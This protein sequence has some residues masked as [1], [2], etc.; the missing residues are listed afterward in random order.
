MDQVKAATVG[1]NLLTDGGFEAGPEGQPG[2]WVEE[3]GTLDEV[4]M[5]ATW[6]KEAD[7][8]PP[9]KIQPPKA[10]PKDKNA[11]WDALLKPAEKPKPLTKE[12]KE[13]KQCLLL[14]VGHRSQDP[15]LQ[16]WALEG[17]YLAYNSPPVRL[18]P[19]SLVQISGWI[20]IPGQIQGSPDGALLFDSA[21]GE[22]LAVRLIEPTPWK[23]F[24]LYRKVPASG[25]I[26]VTVALTG[27]GRVYFDD[28]RIEP[29]GTPAVNTAQAP[30]R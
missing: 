6:V 4:N 18:P 28:I 30:Q 25:M 3:K 22:P 12:V 11:K 17:T 7:P 29:L 23:K 15:L 21:G 10:D 20:Q 27:M 2:Q 9:P 8:P 14:E 1:T 13:G 24:T 26:S 5:K 16:P 19:G